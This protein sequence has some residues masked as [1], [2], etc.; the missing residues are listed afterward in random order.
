MKADDLD[1]ALQF[2]TGYVI[3]KVIGTMTNKSL[4]SSEYHAKM[5]FE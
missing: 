4:T 1:K 3:R 2:N 5:L